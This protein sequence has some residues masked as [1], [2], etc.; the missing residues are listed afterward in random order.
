MSWGWEKIEWHKRPPQ[1]EAQVEPKEETR[2]LVALGTGRMTWTSEKVPELPGLARVAWLEQTGGHRNREEQAGQAGQGGGGWREM[3]DH[4]SPHDQAEQSRAH[5]RT[6]QAREGTAEASNRSE[7]ARGF[8]FFSSGGGSGCRRGLLLVSEK[9]R[10][11]R[12]LASGI[13][14]LLSFG[15]NT[16]G[17]CSADRQTEDARGRFHTQ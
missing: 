2:R 12:R 13:K 6:G 5:A 3:R 4:H 9:T 7:R 16:A 14:L 8:F 10:G 17:S 15:L 11:G 1:P